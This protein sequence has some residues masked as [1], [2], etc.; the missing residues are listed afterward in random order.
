MTVLDEVQD[1]IAA[2]Q[3]AARTELERRQ[4]EYDGL[5][6]RLVAGDESESD[7]A[8]VRELLDALGKTVSELRN[9]VNRQ[10]A[11]LAR[12]AP[13]ARLEALRAKA[14]QVL[15]AANERLDAAKREW[16]RQTEPARRVLWQADFARRHG[17]TSELRQF[18]E[19]NETL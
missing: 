8:F 12:A 19:T 17:Y 14:E 11:E 1:A 7:P 6:E 18:F 3:E 2:E 9:T 10:K 13:L 15:A 16:E 4:Q 5:V